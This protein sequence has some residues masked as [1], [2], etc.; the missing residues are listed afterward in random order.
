VEDWCHLSSRTS[1]PTGLKAAVRVISKFATEMGLSLVNECSDDRSVWTWQTRAG[2]DDG[3][4]LLAHLDV[5]MDLETPPIAF[6]RDPEWLCGE[7]VGTSRAPIVCMQSAL[8]ALRSIRKLRKVPLGLLLYTDEGREC[9]YSFRL[10]QAAAGKA[11]QVLVLRPGILESSVIT[12]RRGWRKYY[13][14]VTGESRKLGRIYKSR[15]VLRWATDCL[16]NFARLTSKE[17]RVAVAASE[18]RTESY[19][20][21]LPHRI[22]AT[23]FVSYLNVKDAVAAE[24]SMR[25]TIKTKDFKCRLELVSERPSLKR[26][27]KGDLLYK[28]LKGIA[29][30]WEIPLDKEFSLSP[31]A[32]GLVPKK[33]PVI[34]GIGPVARD[35]DTPHESVLRISLMQRTLLLAQYLASKAWDSK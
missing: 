6:R 28:K 35:L 30:K 2:M 11:R 31:S 10:I 1:D 20:Q 15:G 4:L 22:V 26:S 19:P 18:V 13:F 12:Q 16:D 29:D 27:R 21:M 24:M 9:R 32:G 33:I 34:C 3:I 17:K 23:V 14:T 8:R 25:N 7:G 5:P